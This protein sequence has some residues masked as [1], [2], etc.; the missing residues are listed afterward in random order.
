MR[1]EVSARRRV[2]RGQAL[3]EFIILLPVMVLAI[4]LVLEDY[5]VQDREQRANMALWYLLRGAT[6]DFFHTGPST[7]ALIDDAAKTFFPDVRRPD[8]VEIDLGAFSDDPFAKEDYSKIYVNELPLGLDVLGGFGVLSGDYSLVREAKVKVTFKNPFP[9]PFRPGRILADTLSVSAHGYIWASWTS[10]VTNPAD[11]ENAARGKGEKA[12]GGSDDD[13][14]LAM[15][16]A[17][18]AALRARDQAWK[19]WQQSANFDDQARWEKAAN[20][21]EQ[22]YEGLSRQCEALFGGCQPV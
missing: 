18:G 13:A 11:A 10:M 5:V 1:V 9:N 3:I 17:M 20:E 19:Q 16:K 15:E 22:Q 6:Y 4:C 7:D 12:R 8:A 14:K 2:A 21:A